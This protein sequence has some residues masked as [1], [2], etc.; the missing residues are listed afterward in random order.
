M[1]SMDAA[2]GLVGKSLRL[3]H[4]INQLIR[5]HPNSQ[6]GL[7]SGNYFLFPSKE[8]NL[9]RIC[10]RNHS[11]IHAFDSI[12]LYVQCTGVNTIKQE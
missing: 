5:Q 1:G 6:L 8:F 3:P 2:S 12:K 7:I 10:A 11:A 4:A 9:L